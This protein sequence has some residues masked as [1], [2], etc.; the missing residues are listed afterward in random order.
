MLDY[1]GPARAKG[2]RNSLLFLGHRFPNVRKTTA[3]ALYLKLLANEDIVDEVK[4]LIY[5]STRK[6]A[7]IR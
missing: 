4:R 3:E 7:H 6:I 2:L 5:R 1:T